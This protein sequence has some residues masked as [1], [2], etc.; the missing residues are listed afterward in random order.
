MDKAENI[1]SDGVWCAFEWV[2]IAVSYGAVHD[3]VI[4]VRNKSD[5]IPDILMFSIMK[6]I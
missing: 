3:G 5:Y 1:P 4:K 6:I 2:W